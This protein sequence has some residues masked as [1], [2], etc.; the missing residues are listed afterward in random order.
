MTKFDA[1]TAIAHLGDGKF[2]GTIAPGWR[3]VGPNGGYVAAL[4]LRALIAASVMEGVS[5]T[6]RHARSL[7]V[8]FLSSP[9]EGPVEIATNI[10]KCGKTVTFVS[11]ELIQDSRPTCLARAVFA[12]ERDGP[13]FADISPPP[14]AS[15]SESVANP[16]GLEVPEISDRF[17]TRHGYGPLP[18]SAGSEA[19]TGGWIRYVEDRQLDHLMLTLL[20]DAWWPAVFARVKQGVAVPTIDITI[21]FRV[22]H[23]EKFVQQSEHCMAVFRSRIASEGFVEE[24]GEIW[25]PGGKLLA[26]SRQLALIT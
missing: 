8:H 15:L 9:H 7:T 19:V 5:D 23:P 14:V 18:F 12:A 17:D 20:A 22:A 13:E 4:L 6:P 2:S 3:A 24:D 16:V 1:D 26:H 21:H 25:S 11:G 10:D